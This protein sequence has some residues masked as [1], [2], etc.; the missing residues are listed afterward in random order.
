MVG[1]MVI[2]TIAGIHTRRETS[3]L[4]HHYF[5]GMSFDGSASSCEREIIAL[6]DT[7]ESTCLVRAVGKFLRLE[8][9][10]VT[11][12][13]FANYLRNPHIDLTINFAGA[14]EQNFDR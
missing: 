5:L 4:S 14:G 13:P 10:T 1:Q 8:V 3:P 9:S 2:G 12:W 7:E 6:R 11:S